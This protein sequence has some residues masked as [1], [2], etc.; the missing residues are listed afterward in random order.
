MSCVLGFFPPPVAA[1]HFQHSTGCNKEYCQQVAASL[2]YYFIFHCDFA[3]GLERTVDLQGD[4]QHL[5]RFLQ[6]NSVPLQ[7]ATHLCCW[8]SLLFGE[9]DDDMIEAAKALL[10]VF[11]HHRY[12]H[13]QNE[14]LLK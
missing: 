1:M 11:L 8:L 14:Q 12:K 3:A 2:Y 9:Q 10:S 5:W 6:R 13:T 7:D 4:F